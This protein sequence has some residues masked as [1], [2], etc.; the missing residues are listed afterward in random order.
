MKVLYALLLA[1]ALPIA[2]V[3][4]VAAATFSNV[5]YADNAETTLRC[6]ALYECTITLQPG[7]QI[8]DAYS[9]DIPD[10]DPHDLYGPNN[11]PSVIFRP[12][13]AGLRTNVVMTTDKHVYHL[14]II[15]T[16]GK[17]PAYYSFRY[18]TARP[19]VAFHASPAAVPPAGDVQQLQYQTATVGSVLP[20]QDLS[21]VNLADVCNHDIYR[22]DDQPA[23]W[24]PQIVCN[25]GH[26]TFIQLAPYHAAPNEAPLIE[27]AYADAA[28]PN[29]VATQ[30]VNYT[31]YMAQGRI[32]VDGV[33]DNLVMIVGTN[34][35]IRIQHI[36]SD[37]SALP[38]GTGTQTATGAHMASYGTQTLPTGSS[39]FINNPNAI[40]APQGIQTR[41][42][43]NTCPPVDGST[44]LN[45]PPKSVRTIQY[46]AQAADALVTANAIRHGALSHG[47]FGLFRNPLGYLVTQAAEDFVLSKATDH[48]CPQVQNVESLIITGSALYNTVRTSQP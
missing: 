12:V 48:A 19:G 39:E 15:S 27:A 18:S 28:N 3:A 16:N 38:P 29:V 33:Y 4:N 6:P 10:F 30:L 34:Q 40:A 22:T 5:W 32:V 21:R 26:H 31:P 46:V 41:P 9:A 42:A 35:V 7:E 43:I 45:S 14:L 13:R 25:D 47:I 36:A 17:E 20:A 24:R 2:S 23:E 1:I 8:T 37:G 44:V 11:T